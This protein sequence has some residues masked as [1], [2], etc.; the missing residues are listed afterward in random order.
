MIIRALSAGG[1]IEGHLRP[2]RERKHHPYW[3][4]VEGSKR[5]LGMRDGGSRG[6][7]RSRRVQN[8]ETHKLVP[9]GWGLC[10]VGSLSL[11]RLAVP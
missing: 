9:F 7:S 10:A 4:L 6:Q 2:H 1:E 5:A 11:F 8:F 3:R